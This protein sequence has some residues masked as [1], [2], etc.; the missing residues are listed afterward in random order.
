MDFTAI[1]I[2]AISIAL[3]IYIKKTFKTLSIGSM[4]LITGGV[5][6]GKSTL[7]VYLVMREYKARLRRWKFHQFIYKITKFDKFNYEK[8][9]LYSNVPL[10]CEYVPVTKDLLLRKKRFAYGSV[11]YLQESS[12][13][14]D[15]MSYKAVNNDELLLFNKLIGHETQ[16][17]CLIYDT[18]SVSDNHFAVK[19]CIN[20]YFYIQKLV[21]WLPFFLVAYV[22]E[23]RYSDDG[24]VVSVDTKDVGETTK[25]VLIPRSI[26]KKFDCYCYSALTDYLPV[27]TQTIDNKKGE[28]MKAHFIVS[29]KEYKTNEKK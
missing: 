9:L 14:A 16:G 13:I 2:I 18:Q 4:S 20:N 12:L 6:C 15:S 29:F 19:R 27:V 11:I 5:K 23:C 8:P 1:L 10:K 17:G 7:S 22:R 3:Y 26:W 24:S 25:R 21:K 28:N